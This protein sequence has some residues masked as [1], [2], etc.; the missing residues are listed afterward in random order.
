MFKA[1]VKHR[2]IVFEALSPDVLGNR[3]R[4]MVQDGKYVYCDPG[5]PAVERDSKN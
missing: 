5:Q 2:Y 4:Q 1:M 3:V